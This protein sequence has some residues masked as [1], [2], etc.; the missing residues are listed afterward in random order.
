M[1]AIA[2]G[3]GG[4]EEVPCR[5]EHF[6]CG[7]HCRPGFVPF[8]LELR[9]PGMGEDVLGRIDDLVL[10]DFAPRARRLRRA[11]GVCAPCLCQSSVSS[12]RR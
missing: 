2:L 1:A 7:L 8:L 6:G 5:V 12:T 10:G 3:F 4:A 11:S 9:D